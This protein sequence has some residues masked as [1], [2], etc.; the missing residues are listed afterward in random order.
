MIATNLE[1]IGHQVPMTPLIKKAID[2]LHRNNISRLPEGRVDIDEERVFAIVQRY[3]TIPIEAPKFEAHRKYI[4][5]QYIASGEEIIGWAPI[6]RMKITDAYD[7]DNDVCLGTM[8]EAQWTPLSLKE[9]QLAVFWPEDGHSPKLAVHAPIRVMK[10]V[11]KVSS[12]F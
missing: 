3:E 4:D 11:I 6:E 12:G 8:P 7:A 10:I 1:N 9:G 2:F 5:I